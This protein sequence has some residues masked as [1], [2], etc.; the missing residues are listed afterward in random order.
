MNKKNSDKL[1]NFID[2]SITKKDLLKK[3]FPKLKDESL[4]SK[5]KIDKD[6]VAYITHEDEANEITN[7]L[8]RYLNKLKLDSKNLIITEATANVGGNVLS[9]S[10]SFK[11]VYAIEIVKERAEYLENNLKIYKT[12]NVEVINGDC[13]KILPELQNQDIIFFDPPWG[14]IGYKKYNNLK[15]SLSGISLESICLNIFENKTYK[16]KP[17]IIALKL[18]INFDLNNF[19]KKLKNYE[20]HIHKVNKMIL[21][22]LIKHL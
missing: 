3:V 12:N 8:I 6:S 10:N 15:L 21:I 11:K 16:S 4:V 5:L 14:G 13:L 19:I 2:N 22:I 9:F 1:N 17:N 7:I 18:P 20:F